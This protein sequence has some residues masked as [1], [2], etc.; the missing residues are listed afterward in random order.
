MELA[1]LCVSLSRLSVSRLLLAFSPGVVGVVFSFSA[2][3][4]W[5]AGGVAAWPPLSPDAFSPAEPISL[6]RAPRAPRGARQAL[7]CSTSH[8]NGEVFRRDRGDDRRRI[9]DQATDQCDHYWSAGPLASR[10]CSAATVS[11]SEWQSSTMRVQAASSPSKAASPANGPRTVKRTCRSAVADASPRQRDG[12]SPLAERS[13]AC[14]ATPATP[15]AAPPSPT[16]S[17]NSANASRGA[18]PGKLAQRLS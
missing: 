11:G 9:S 16:S 8:K 18:R 10:S 1:P 3:C 14:H 13:A 5:P 12:R 2:D 17:R 7:T 6:A 4:P 15:A